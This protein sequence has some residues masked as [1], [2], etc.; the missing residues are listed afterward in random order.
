MAMYER[1]VQEYDKNNDNVTVGTIFRRPEI[2]P[3]WNT[4]LNQ[5]ENGVNFT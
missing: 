2:W 4:K 1:G 5:E 3:K